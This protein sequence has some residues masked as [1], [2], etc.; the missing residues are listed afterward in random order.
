MWGE[1]PAHPAGQLLFFSPSADPSGLATPRNA[2]TVQLMTTTQE[3][4][5]RGYPA[6]LTLL[7]AHA[8]ATDVPVE[9]ALARALFAAAERDA[10]PL[11]LP[12]PLPA[13]LYRRCR[14]E[15]AGAWAETVQAWRRRYGM[16]WPQAIHAAT[17]QV[18]VTA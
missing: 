13:A 14:P 2:A 10:S 3:F 8:T 7:K 12:A 17:A 11:P 4:F 16:T 1:C 6:D 15:D 9:V 5:V 18:G